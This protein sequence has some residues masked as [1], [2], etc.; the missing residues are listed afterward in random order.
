MKKVLILAYDFPPY[1]SVGGLRPYNWLKY[2]KEFDVEPIVI[3]RQWGNTYGNELDYIAPSKRQDVVTE[4]LE[5]GTI[6]RTPY[7][8]NLSN[9]LLLK[10]GE[11]RFRILRKA[12]SAY[13]EFA[14]Y[15][16]ITGPK[17]ELYTVAR[18]YLK[19]NPVDV[20]IATGDPF[21]LFSYASKLNKEYKIP[22]IADYRDLWSN[23]GDYDTN[24]LLKKYNE[25]CEKRILKQVKQ[26]TTVSEFFKK[27]IQKIGFTQPFH[28]LANGFDDE[29]VTEAKFV[30]VEKEFLSIG[31]AGT[32]YDYHPWQSFIKVYCEYIQRNPEVRIQMN[33]YGV[34][35][36]QQIQDFIQDNY[37]QLLDYFSF[38]PRIPNSQVLE[39]LA[40]NHV[41]LLF[42]DYSIIGTKIYDYLG[43]QRK[44]ILCYANDNEAITL[45]E[46]HYVI[47]EIDG[48]SQALQADLIQETNSGIVVEDAA[49]LK[50]VLQDLWEEFKNT[51]DIQCD[52]INIEK[53][54]RKEQVKKLAAIIH[55]LN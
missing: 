24:F 48:I 5:Y 14:Q 21:I 13:Y 6:I 45:K 28:V 50:I 34:N 31:L 1:V 33:F 4:V 26:I 53:Y 55:Q 9:R 29:F 12:I 19:K 30:E 32:I 27:K 46:K 52:S 47:E 22:Y 10:Y 36:E 38:T 54:S 2:L 51:Q 40:T 49:H 37:P 43:I 23:S 11:N 42:N 17:K 25:F 8:P 7:K 16:F 3:T 44:I 18:A 20:I 41:M 15:F 35:S 39:K